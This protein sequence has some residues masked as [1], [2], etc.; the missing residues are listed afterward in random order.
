MGLI[1]ML[2]INHIYSRE[3]SPQSSNEEKMKTNKLIKIHYTTVIY[4][5]LYKILTMQHFFWWNYHS[6]ETVN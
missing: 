3:Q 1:P 6:L 5:T 4:Q 2:S